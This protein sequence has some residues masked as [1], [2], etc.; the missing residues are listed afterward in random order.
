MKKIICILLSI[1]MLVPMTAFAAEGEQE[2]KPVITFNQSIYMIKGKHE[3]VNVSNV[4]KNTKITFKSSDKKVATVNNEGKINAKKCGNA[5]ITVSTTKNGVSSK[6]KIKVTVAISRNRIT[7]VHGTKTEIVDPV[8]TRPVTKLPVMVKVGKTTNL[9]ASNLVDGDTITY[10][11]SDKDIATVNSQGKITAKKVGK[12]TIIA[13]VRRD[14]KNYKCKERIYVVKAVS[15]SKITKKER[16]NYY[17]TSAFIGSSI[18]VGQ[19]YYFNSQGKGYLGNPLMLVRGCYSFNN[20]KNRNTKYMVQYKGVSMRAKDAV[21]KSGVDKVFI[22][23]GTNDLFQGVDKTYSQ[24]IDYIEGIKKESP[25]VIIFIESMTSVHKSK[26]K[27]QLNSAN[28]RKLNNKLKSY[29]SKHKDYYYVDVSSEMNDEKGHLMS[30]YSSDNYVHLTN[31]AY[32]LWMNKLTA[33]TDK[34]MINEQNAEDAVKTAVESKDESQIEKAEKALK[35]L[36]SSSFKSKLKKQLK[37][38]K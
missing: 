22:A 13:T 25:N 26:Q 30:K 18:G 23:M 31:S 36:Q 14:G 16:N 9:T 20:D 29:C 8:D 15:D 21:R 10:T 3:Y 35:K 38:A 6:T 4:D 17:S 24:Y 7:K 12:A 32:E 1:L 27:K 19:K 28:V 37:Q 2:E 5:T 33:Y 34:L 11:T